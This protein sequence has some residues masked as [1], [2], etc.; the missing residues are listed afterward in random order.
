M[1]RIISSFDILLPTMLLLG[2]AQS[3]DAAISVTLRDRVV[4]ESSVVRLGDV[5]VVASADR[6]NGRQLDAVP[7][8]PSPPPGTERFLGKQEVV[9][10]LA[11]RGYD[12][13][14]FEFEGA[15]QVAI[16]S[17][18]DHPVDKDVAATRPT[19][20][21]QM[22]H[23]AAVLANQVGPKANIAVDELAVAKLRDELIA[24]ITSYLETQSGRLGEW[25]VVCNVP[26]RHLALLE[27]A[28]SPIVCQGG[29]EPWIGRQRFV[30]SFST[31]Q[32]SMKIP[33]HAEVAGASARV[34]V[35]IRPIARG[36]VITAAD[37][38]LQPLE[39][40]PPTGRRV[41]VDS[42]EQLVGMEARQE[43]A[44][45]DVIHKD[46][47]Q[48]PL[49][50]KRG[51]EITVVSQSGGIRVR[52]TARARQDGAHGQLVQVETMESK[53]RYD[54][55]VIGVREAAVFA[56]TGLTAVPPSSKQIETANR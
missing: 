47:L 2:A 9:D 22:N 25:R 14:E 51:E 48:A 40:A 16:S 36:N 1:T 43:I 27:A 28:T 23:H 21:P 29:R 6:A 53:E 34:A 13:H 44:V 11:A 37:V 4:V 20:D 24:T 5:A 7:L 26:A 38:E 32:G 35:A 46:Q 54:V 12:L 3:S 49:L 39:S 31:T 42:L 33:V 45:G 56:A 18:K 19:S 10:L 55:R 8:I 52:T 17:P 30:I 41:V 15:M 50:V